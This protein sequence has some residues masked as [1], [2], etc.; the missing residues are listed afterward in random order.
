MSSKVY[1]LTHLEPVHPRKGNDVRFFIREWDTENQQGKSHTLIK[2]IPHWMYTKILDQTKAEELHHHLQQNPAFSNLEFSLISYG[3]TRS[4]IRASGDKQWR[5]TLGQ[6]FLSKEQQSATPLLRM[7]YPP[8]LQLD[9]LT[10]PNNDKTSPPQKFISLE[11]LISDNYAVLDIEIESWEQGQDSI[12]M[13]VYQSPKNKIIF[14]NLPFPAPSWQNVQLIQY[15]TQSELGDKLTSLIQQEDPLWLIG[16]NIM[17]FDQLKLRN[18]TQ[19]YLPSTNEHYPVSKSSIKGF[20]KVITKGRFTL[21][22][23]G[24]LRHFRNFFADNSL[25]T[26]AN[27]EKSITYAQQTTLVQQARA[28]DKQ[29]FE[30]LVSYC[31]DDG[32]R[33]AQLGL[34]ILPRISTIA[35]TWHC[36]PDS[37]C[38]TSKQQLAKQYWQQRYFSR[39]N[40][41][42]TTPQYIEEQTKEQQERSTWNFGKPQIGIFEGEVL[43]LTPWL[44]ASLPLL[45]KTAPTLLKT[46]QQEKHPLAKVELLQALTSHLEFIW[47]EAEHIVEHQTI[48]PSTNSPNLKDSNLPSQSYLWYYNLGHFDLKSWLEEINNKKNKTIKS[49]KHHGFINQGRNFTLVNGGIDSSHLENGLYG[50]YLGKGKI[51][52]LDKN[53]FIANPFAEHTIE[54]LIYQ[55]IDL[56]HGRHTPFEKKLL[57]HCLEQIFFHNNQQ[58]LKSYIESNVLNYE[59]GSLPTEEYLLAI[60]Q[61]TYLK[62][63][64]AEIMARQQIAPELQQ[65]YHKLQKSIN[66]HLNPEQS[67]ELN[68][69][70]ELC[71]SNFSYPYL[72]ELQQQIEHP[73]PPTLKMAYGADGPNRLLPLT[74]IAHLDYS[75]YAQRAR[76]YLN[77]IL[78]VLNQSPNHSPKYSLNNSSNQAKQLKQSTQQEL[79]LK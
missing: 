14:H 61:L 75:F 52:S 57:H 49:I 15:Q 21:D 6:P 58:D 73:Y 12:F 74:L 20:K 31:V 26:S 56:T 53:K 48:N 4:L 69:I 29:A 5:E 1:Y 55:G 32:K 25:E 17:N 65:R 51:L 8:L 24:Y 34:E 66:Q 54:R 43:Y 38:S 70:I 27:F 67:K 45:E 9:S 46:F 63:E 35:Q 50:C 10:I 78:S 41:R 18:L 22:T 77:P 68:Q 71:H 36:D 13:V 79:F 23:L 28:G 33:A 16:H 47:H 44:A 76:N 42:P 3:K 2:D 59:N 19:D 72:K 40:I 62:K 39:T 37:I 60:N 11:H 64:I 7:R 30:T